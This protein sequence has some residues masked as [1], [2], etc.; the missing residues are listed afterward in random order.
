MIL[1]PLSVVAIG[2][3]LA[4]VAV[5]WSRR[6]LASGA[7]AIAN[8][9]V[10][11]M[12][13]NS[14]WVEFHGD[15]VPLL[16]AELGLWS[17]NLSDEMPL[18]ALQ[19]FTS[20]F[21]HADFMHLLGNLIILLAF[22]LPFEELIGGRR[23]LVVYLLAGLAGSLAQVAVS[24][25]GGPLLLMGASGAIFGIIGAFAA[26][27][28]NRVVPLP[29]PLFVVMFFVRMRVWIAAM[30]FAS[31]QLL[32]LAFLSPFDNTAYFAH[33]GGLGGGILLGW[34]VVRGNAPAHRSPVAV[35]LDALTPFARDTGTAAAL[36]Q[37][38][39]NHDEP[40]IFQ[41]WLDRFFRTASCPTCQHK[42]MPRHHGEI[43]CTQGHR[44]DVRKDRTRPI[45]A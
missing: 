21:V 6:F 4:A 25:G 32:Y 31:L 37:M 16:Q 12:S 42:V 33:L 18:A 8:V 2:I 38:K 30:V 3:M 22:A 44:F 7:L 20:L 45:A 29:L 13:A 10:W 23:F 43:V 28:P 14:P 35:E 41:A 40:Q 15:A 17:P 5:G 1:S 34:A 24:W 19:L 9:V 39:T 36:A 27:Y 11:L 26:S